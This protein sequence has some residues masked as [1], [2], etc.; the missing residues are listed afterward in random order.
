MHKIFAQKSRV[1]PVLCPPTY[2]ENINFASEINMDI[3]IQ[4]SDATVELFAYIIVFVAT[5]FVSRKR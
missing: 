2:F 4:L 5:G 1:A 3:I